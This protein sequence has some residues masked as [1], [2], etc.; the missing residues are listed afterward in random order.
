MTS[1]AR[2][3]TD[4][5][6][7]NQ[8]LTTRRAVL[9][10]LAGGGGA[11][12]LVDLVDGDSHH[13]AVSLGGNS[14]E[15][16]AAAHRY[17]GLSTAPQTIPPEGDRLQWFFGDDLGVGEL[18]G[19]DSLP[20]SWTASGLQF[21]A[22]TTLSAARSQAGAPG[23]ALV[24]QDGSGF[25]EVQAPD[26]DERFIAE[27]IEIVMAGTLG[28]AQSLHSGHTPAVLFGLDGAGEVFVDG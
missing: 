1:K 18:R 7:A 12:A 26:S 24:Y 2:E 10:A 11:A 8:T 25:F 5:S 21:G 13:E 19:P 28:A 23:I 22:A 17:G 27:G 14:R 15:S 9:G 3:P 16:A 20:A 6:T 4:D